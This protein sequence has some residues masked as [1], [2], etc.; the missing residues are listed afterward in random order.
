MSYE[1]LF[2][3]YQKLKA[4]T[5]QLQEEKTD[6]NQKLQEQR[7]EYEQRLAE[8]QRQIEELRRQ[9]FGPKSDRLT[10]EQEAQLNELNKDM[11]DETQRSDSAVDEML[12][13]E[14]SKKRRKRKR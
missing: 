11:Q 5:E 10:S 3:E 7:E 12:Q 8:A 1:E 4:L 2:A 6:L 13:R 9:L 14:E